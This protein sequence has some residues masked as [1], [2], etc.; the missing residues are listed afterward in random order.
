MSERRAYDPAYEFNYDTKTMSEEERKKL[1]LHQ[2]SVVQ[3]PEKNPNPNYKNELAEY[4]HIDETAKY[5]K[6]KP[7]VSQFPEKNPNPNYKNELAEYSHIDE[8][9][10]YMIQK[11]TVAQFTDKVP[12]Y[13]H[14]RALPEKPHLPE[15][16]EY[17][18]RLQLHQGS[19]LQLPK[20]AEYE[21]VRKFIPFRPNKQ[22]MAE[23][24]PIA[25]VPNPDHLLPSQAKRMQTYI[26]HPSGRT[27][28]SVA[29]ASSA[30]TSPTLS[31]KQHVWPP[32]RSQVKQL[33]R[34]GFN[35]AVT[36]ADGEY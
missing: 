19:V 15:E 21:R 5:M 25:R 14:L 8:S 4:S 18:R 20:H 28:R 29:F 6:Q 3:F 11:P 1:K 27:M 26:T 2:G 17:N 24:M 34:T 32:T 30:P 16:E 9:T 35:P 12:D 13:D 33:P 31:R 36:Y 23:Q 10:R 7:T 22:L